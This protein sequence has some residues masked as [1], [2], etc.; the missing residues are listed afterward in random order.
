MN[1]A[2]R[3]NSLLPREAEVLRDCM[4][5]LEFR[6]IPFERQNTGGLVPKDGCR[7]VRFGTPGRSDLSGILPDGRRLEIEVKRP[8]KRPTAAQYAWLRRINASGGA[9]IWV[10]DVR[11]LDAALDRL[12]AGCRVEIDEAGACWITDEPQEPR[13]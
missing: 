7:Y 13:Q 8:G 1:K 3:G 2:R 11:Q 4:R 12:L 6:G 9:G 5:L 10:S